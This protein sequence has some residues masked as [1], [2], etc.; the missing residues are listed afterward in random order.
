LVKVVNV[1]A[2]APDCGDIIWVNF[3]PQAGHEQGGHR[4][5]VVLSPRE[6]N[7][8]VGLLVCV[9]MTTRIKGFRFEVP[10][11]GKPPSVALSDHVKSVDWR[12]RKATAKGKVSE[13]E[14]AQIRARVAVLVGL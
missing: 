13:R 8:K 5:A 1:P 7:H 2:A 6:Y 10:I 11:E 3:D 14:L 12:A 4:P 9:P